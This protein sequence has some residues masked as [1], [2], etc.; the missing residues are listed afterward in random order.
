[1]KKYMWR[2]AIAVGAVAT[3]ILTTAPNYAFR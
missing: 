1:M 3:V 2:A